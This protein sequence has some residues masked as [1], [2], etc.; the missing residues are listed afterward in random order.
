MAV[1]AAILVA[2]SIAGCYSRVTV[3]NPRGTTTQDLALGQD[4]EVVLRDGREIKTVYRGMKDGYLLTDS[5]RYALDQVHR[6]SY[7]IDDDSAPL[8]I[9]CCPVM[10]MG[11]L[12]PIP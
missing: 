4:I 8:P 5:G 11:P 7:W 1:A 10:N 9:F 6:L 12:V 2:V 3:T